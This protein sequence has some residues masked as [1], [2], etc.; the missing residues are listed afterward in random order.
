M[1]KGGVGAEA[2][3]EGGS[4]LEEPLLSTLRDEVGSVGSTDTDDD[5]D[6]ET[7]SHIDE[8]MR[9]TDDAADAELRTAN[10]LDSERCCTSAAVQPVCL[11]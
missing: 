9:A 11:L 8:V 4:D 3:S 7:G 10:A 5:T 1:V 2:G 6:S